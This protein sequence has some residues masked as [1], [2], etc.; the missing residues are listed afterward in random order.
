M[1]FCAVL[2]LIGLLAGCTTTSQQPQQ[3]ERP[4]V[5]YSYAGPGPG[6]MAAIPASLF[7]RE[8]AADLP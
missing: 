1:R 3:P 6:R 7:C 8:S 5:R 4:A 2:I